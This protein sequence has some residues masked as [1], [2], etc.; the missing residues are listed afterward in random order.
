MENFLKMSTPV[1]LQNNILVELDKKF[2]DEI[3]SDGGIKFYKDTTFRPEWGV[4]I[5]GKVIS[6]PKK[7]TIGDGQVHSL[8]PD[9]VKINQNVK[10][11][12]EIIFSYLVVMN[13]AMTD[14]AGEIFTREQPISPYI[15]IWTNPNGLQIIREY[16]MNNKYQIALLDTKTKIVVDVVKGGEK[17]VE[18]FMA[19]YMPTEN[20]GFNYRN[21]FPFKDKDYWMVDYANAVAIKRKDGY[22]MVG[23]YVLLQPIREPY[24]GTYEGALE[25]HEIKQDTDYRAT[26]RLLSIGEPL[27]GNKKLS[28]KPNDI[29]VTDIRY[30]EKYEIDGKDYWIVRQ[31]YIY[32]KQ[33]VNNEY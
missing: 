2:Q 30:V 23:D 1:C 6:T 26:A 28:V 17:A 7:I 11:G 16:H 22:E 24:R 15:T 10:V 33:S 14:N 9:R 18:D 19:K 29:I 27:K 3:I 13:R 32:G 20:H 5:S 8:D 25:I 12:D 21:I 4:T 31:K